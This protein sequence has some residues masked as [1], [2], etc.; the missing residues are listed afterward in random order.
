MTQ[1]EPAQPRHTADEL[2]AAETARDAWAAEAATQ[3]LRAET[4]EAELAENTGVL[5]ALRRQRDTAEAERDA[6]RNALAEIR[7]LHTHG[8]I[9][10]TCNDCGEFWPCSTTQALDRHQTQETT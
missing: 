1:P 5:Q 4:A 9:T 10:N 7:A 8:R 3:T 6:A 2:R